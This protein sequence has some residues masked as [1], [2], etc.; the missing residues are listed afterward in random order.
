MPQNHNNR[1]ING[2]CYHTVFQTDSQNANP[3]SYC[4]YQLEILLVRRQS[5]SLNRAQ[6]HI[7]GHICRCRRRPATP[8]P[9]RRPTNTL[10]HKYATLHPTITMELRLPAGLSAPLRRLRS[11]ANATTVVVKKCPINVFYNYQAQNNLRQKCNTAVHRYRT[12]KK[13]TPSA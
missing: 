12:H 3:E 1:A 4:M 6:A 7:H 2:T 13:T 11:T 5:W 8:P 9:S 10:C